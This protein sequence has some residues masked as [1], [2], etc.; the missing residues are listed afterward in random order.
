[1][2]AVPVMYVPLCR[3]VASEAP[4][5][6]VRATDNNTDTYRIYPHVG[7]VMGTELQVSVLD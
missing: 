7:R 2:H 5:L 6:Y 3:E 4:D 1:M